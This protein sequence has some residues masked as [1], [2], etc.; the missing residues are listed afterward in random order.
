MNWNF[1]QASQEN[2]C[3]RENFR[4]ICL[5]KNDN[6]LKQLEEHAVSEQHCKHTIRPTKQIT[7]QN[8]LRIEFLDLAENKVFKVNMMKIY[9]A[10]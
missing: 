8:F 6:N 4:Y 3:E 7:N 2:V 10:L 9:T 1:V 5:A